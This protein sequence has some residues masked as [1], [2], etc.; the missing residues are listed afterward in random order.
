MKGA[1][2]IEAT[3]N[4]EEAAANELKARIDASLGKAEPTT[5]YIRALRSL[6]LNKRADSD[7]AMLK[8]H[9]HA[10]NR[11]ITATQLAKAVG[12]PNYSTVNLRYGSLGQAIYSEAVVNLPTTARHPDGKPIYTFVIADGERLQGDDWRWTM[13]SEV[14]NAMAALGL[15]K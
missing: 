14:A 15:E 6:M 1:T 10:P 5:E 2:P 7:S 11:T 13:R 9:Y 8:A 4:T 3:V 12:F